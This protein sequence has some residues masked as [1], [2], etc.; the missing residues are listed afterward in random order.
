VKAVKDAISRVCVPYFLEGNKGKEF[1]VL[2]EIGVPRSGEV[3]KEEV[4]KALPGG[5]CYRVLRIDVKEG[6]LSTRCVGIR[7]L[8]DRSDE[9]IVAVAAITIF[10][11]D[12]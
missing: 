7:D 6:G 1:A 9:M 2:V 10:V 4:S 3:D 12:G 8:G 11:R 5:E